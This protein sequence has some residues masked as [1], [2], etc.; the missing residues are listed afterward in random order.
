LAVNELQSFL[1]DLTARLVPF[2]RNSWNILNKSVKQIA[3]A[4][5]KL[6]PHIKESVPFYEQSFYPRK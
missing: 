6:F 1:I 5:P 4:M 2:T 3:P